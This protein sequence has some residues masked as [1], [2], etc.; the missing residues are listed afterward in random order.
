MKRNIVILFFFLISFFT[1]TSLISQD[2]YGFN[3]EKDW[4][5]GELLADN[6]TALF[7]VQKEIIFLRDEFEIQ[8]GRKL[9]SSISK[10]DSLNQIKNLDI[11]A[12]KDLEKNTSKFLKFFYQD[13]CHIDFADNFAGLIRA[14]VYIAN[15]RNKFAEEKKLFSSN[16]F[17]PRNIPKVNATFL[18]NTEFSYAEIILKILKNNYSD[19]EI[20]DKLKPLFHNEILSNN[21]CIDSETLVTFLK[22]VKDNKPL[23]NIYIIANPVS[24]FCLGLVNNYL[25]EFENSLIEI[26]NEEENIFAYSAYLLSFIFKEGLKLNNNVNYFYG[27]RNCEWRNN[28]NEIIFDLSRFGNNYD[29]FAKY[30]TRELLFDGKRIVQIDVFKYLYSKNDLLFLNLFEK[31]YENGIA[32]F[33][34]PI[35]FDNRPSALLE[36]DFQLFKRTFRTINENKPN[37]VIDS[38]MNIGINESYFSSM[39]S[40]MSYSID[41]KL[42]RNSL[43]RSLYLGALYF[44]K[45]YID[46]YNLEENGI[47][48]VFRLSNEI[49]SKITNMNSKINYNMLEDM[50]KIKSSELDSSIILSKTKELF[51]KYK[52]DKDLWFLHL[53]AGKV[54]MEKNLYASSLSHILY[55]LQG[56]TDKNEFCS[57]IG[58]EYYNSKYYKEAIE[59]FTKYI[60]YS[61]GTT[62]AYNKRGMAYYENGNYDLAKTDFEK[63]I[64]IEP[65]NQTAKEYL[66]K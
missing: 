29:L 46:V 30:L 22:E 63:V 53:L 34:A 42:G 49:E 39:G 32:N 27:N 59:M 40:Q 5:W 11:I 43:Q 36:K 12:T 38:L 18:I 58:T 17:A 1:N 10:L 65:D 2:K 48:S 56:I 62:E 41:V 52:N 51:I 66:Q 25:K 60:T 20:R 8:E 21:N 6:Q 35:V 57:E 14:A 26:K 33:I 4:D 64:S 15:L 61:N 9:L 28:K 24:F 16:L 19:N 37:F 3:F 13:T 55:S 50:I 45:E 54:L 23:T 44:M 7:G 31:V 47:R